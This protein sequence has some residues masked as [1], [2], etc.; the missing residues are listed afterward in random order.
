MVNLEVVRSRLAR[1]RDGST[2][3]VMSFAE[4]AVE[5]AEFVARLNEGVSALLSL[6]TASLGDDG[7]LHC[8]AGKAGRTIR[9]DIDSATTERLLPRLKVLGEKAGFTTDTRDG[10]VIFTVPVKSGTE[11]SK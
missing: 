11:S 1:S 4:Q 2:Q 6:I 3:D 5:Q 10:S 8:S 9:F 7:K